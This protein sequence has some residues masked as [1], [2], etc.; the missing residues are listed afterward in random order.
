MRVRIEDVQLTRLVITINWSNRILV[1][2][3]KSQWM[4]WDRSS[5]RRVDLC[6]FHP[7]KNQLIPPP[8]A[9]AVVVGVVV[10]A[11]MRTAQLIWSWQSPVHKS[12]HMC[13]H[14]RV[15][16]RSTNNATLRLLLIVLL[17]CRPVT[18]VHLMD[19]YFSMFSCR[20]LAL[21]SN[22]SGQLAGWTV[23]L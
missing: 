16:Q 20:R 3:S 15:N 7:L 8:A 4:P 21:V 11:V 5:H 2:R 14:K 13:T 23:F 9:A 19:N 22:Y 18:A 1:S 6:P 17:P 10:V 12:H